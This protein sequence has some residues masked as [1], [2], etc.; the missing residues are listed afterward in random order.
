MSLK[1]TACVFVMVMLMAANAFAQDPGTKSDKTAQEAP[2]AQAPKPHRVRVKE[3][4]QKAKLIHMVYPV[5][6]PAN[7]KRMDGTVVLHVIIGKDGAVKSARYVS[8]PAN[9]R[10]SAV[11]AAQQWRYKPTLINGVPVEV[12][13]T[14]SVVFPPLTKVA[15]PFAN[16]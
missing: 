16:K 9:L 1:I 13:T 3:D 2:A 8:G 11:N 14:V 4:V 5:Y 7:N 10:D 15:R 12:D 6:P